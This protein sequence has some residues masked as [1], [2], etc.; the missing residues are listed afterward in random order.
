[1]LLCW[2]FCDCLEF[3]KYLYEWKISKFKIEGMEYWN[4][5]EY[6]SVFNLKIPSRMH[7]IV[8]DVLVITYLS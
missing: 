6:V 8:K 3:V 1:M 4:S 7:V 2:T 5:M